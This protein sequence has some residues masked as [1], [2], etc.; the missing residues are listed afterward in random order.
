MVNVSYS[1]LSLADVA[2]KLGLDSAEDAEYIV[3]KVT[4]AYP[5]LLRYLAGCSP[6]RV[7]TGLAL[8]VPPTFLLPAVLLFCGGYVA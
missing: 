3:A 4:T 5:R 6:L 7:H 1:R 8:R 2:A